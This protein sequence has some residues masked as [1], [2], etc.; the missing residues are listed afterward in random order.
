MYDIHI[1]GI[2]GPKRQILGGEKS[3]PT[4][5]KTPV[6]FLLRVV[7]SLHRFLAMRTGHGPQRK[8]RVSPH[9]D[10]SKDLGL[11]KL[12]NLSHT[13]ISFLLSLPNLKRKRHLLVSSIIRSMQ[14]KTISSIDTSIMK[15]RLGKLLRIISSSR[16]VP[17]Y[18]I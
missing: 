5:A 18:P 10:Y 8:L 1:V 13:K 12:E 9:L 15:C 14:F 16:Y 7:L 6:L 17:P 3:L 11:T 2:A 4:T